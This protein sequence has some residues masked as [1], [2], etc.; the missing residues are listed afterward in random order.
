MAKIVV[1]FKDMV[2]QEY[3]LTNPI[4]AIGR[5]PTNDIPIDNLAVSRFHAQVVREGEQFVVEDMNSN[6]GVFVNGERIQKHALKDGDNITIGKHLL[7]YVEK[8]D[9]VRT[10]PIVTAPSGGSAVEESE[11]TIMMD[12]GAMNRARAQHAPAAPAKRPAAPPP[13]PRKEPEVL[14]ALTVLQGNLERKRY[15]LTNPATTV[16]KGNTAE[17]RLSGFLMPSLVA[18][19]NRRED[20]YYLTPSGGLFGKPVVNGQAPSE[21]IKLNDG[22]LLEVRGFKFQFNIKK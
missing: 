22:D 15:E 5:N 19:I 21:Q 7:I 14:A 6:N 17:I 13:P 10:D 3:P 8:D 4:T 18:V 11:M 9:A 16:G 1:K 2:R 20:G 12:P